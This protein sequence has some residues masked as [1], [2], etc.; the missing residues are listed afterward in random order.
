M[1]NAGSRVVDFLR[2]T[3]APLA[4]HRVVVVCGKGNNGGD[5]FVV[6]RQLFTRN[7]AVHS[8][9][10]ELF[11]PEHSDGRCAANR[12]CSM[13]AAAPSSAIYETKPILATIVDRR[14]SGHGLTGPA[15]GRRWTPSRSINRRFPLA[16]KV[17][18]DIPSGLPSDE[19]KPTGEFVRADFTVTFTAAKR[20]QCLSPIYEHWASSWWCPSAA[21]PE[22]CE[23]N[24]GFNLDLTTKDDLRHLFAKR[25]ELQQ[26]NV[27][28]CP[29]GRGFVW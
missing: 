17:A 9:V 14:H 21:G 27:R 8:T 16:K 12:K 25:P 2:E 11:R 26:R 10:F 6:A 15:T 19:T 28:P 20:S 7:F 4:K 22:F 24:P 5:G 3:F 18:V 23:T 13:P 1:E 29:G